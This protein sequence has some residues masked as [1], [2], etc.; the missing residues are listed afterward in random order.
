VVYSWLWIYVI[1]GKT[2]AYSYRNPI[3]S[4]SQTV[5]DWRKASL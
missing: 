1:P 5:T 2:K 4:E 3:F